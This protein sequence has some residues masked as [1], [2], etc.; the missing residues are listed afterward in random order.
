M[1]GIT[2]ALRSHDNEIA[3][4]AAMP[5]ELNRWQIAT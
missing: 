1:K 4:L 2:D 5:K 3:L